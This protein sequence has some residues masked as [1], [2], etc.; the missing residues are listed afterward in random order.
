MSHNTCAHIIPN[1]LLDL[2]RRIQS[3]SPAEQTVFTKQNVDQKDKA[4]QVAVAMSQRYDIIFIFIVIC[5]MLK[6][7]TNEAHGF[8][9]CSPENNKWDNMLPF[10]GEIFMSWVP[11]ASV[12]RSHS[13]KIYGKAFPES[14]SG[15]VPEVLLPNP[16]RHW[17]LLQTFC[18]S[19]H[20]CHHHR[21]CQPDPEDQ[22]PLSQE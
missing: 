8:E 2:H 19:H 4:R 11:E 20:Q 3:E 16:P 15:Q 12:M 7:C 9:T 10:I 22:D 5:G 18:Q 17:T 1:K 13:H 14:I 6:I 21:L